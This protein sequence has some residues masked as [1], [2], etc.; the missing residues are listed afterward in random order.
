[1]QISTL[2]RTDNAMSQSIRAPLARMQGQLVSVTATH[3]KKNFVGCIKV[4]GTW[5]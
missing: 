3:E 1:M 4:L 5:H 2:F